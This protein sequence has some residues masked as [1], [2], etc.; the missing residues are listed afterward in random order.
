MT[1][2][3][4]DLSTFSAD[5]LRRYGRQLALP[6]FGIEGQRRLKSASVLIVGA[7]G[8]GSPAA[9]YLAAAGVGRLG[10]VEF[11]R[12]EESNLHRQLLYSSSDTGRSKI[13][14]ARERIEGVNPA[15]E[16]E[17]FDTRLTAANA[18]S[19]LEGFDIVLDGSDNFPTRYLVNDAAVISGIPCVYG[20]VH[21][22][23]GQL[24]V[25]ATKDG[26][27]YRCLFR[28]PPPAGAVPNC[29]E[30]GVL[31]VLPGII[32]TLQATEAIKLI[33]GIGE[34][35]V[36]RLLLFEALAMAFR[37]VELRRD[38]E[39]PS[40]GASA[41]G[42]L[43][44]YE[45]ACDVNAVRSIDPL[46][47]ALRLDR[48]DDIDVV[49]VREPYEWEIARLDGAR[50]VPLGQLELEMESFDPARDTV[51]YCKTGRRSAEAAQKLAGAGIRNVFNLDG[52]VVRWRGEV[53]PTFPQY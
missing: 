46:E 50:L 14:A 13:E 38:P 48:G 53:D 25:F 40:C 23:E 18:L 42:S 29:A 4:T 15:V 22:F 44:D 9:L 35:L 17:S 21:R 11:D 6:S 31:G 10:I 16:V 20:S 19:I 24:S 26:P 47:L 37:T 32:G 51:V 7:G 12:V 43:V 49:D 45:I 34:P 39:C 2:P 27:C 5:E 36:G 28:E 33:A 41:S 1:R 3:E 52:G 8:L 30:A